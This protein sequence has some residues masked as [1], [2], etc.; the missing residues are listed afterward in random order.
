[1]LH[2]NYSEEFIK[3]SVNY[4]DTLLAKVKQKTDLQIKYKG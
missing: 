4:I 1:M 3:E 2:N